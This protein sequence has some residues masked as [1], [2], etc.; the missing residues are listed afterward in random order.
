MHEGYWRSGFGY[1]CKVKCRHGKNNVVLTSLRRVL[2]QRVQFESLRNI[3][4]TFA[5]QQHAA[6]CTVHA[7]PGGEEKPGVKPNTS[8]SPSHREASHTLGVKGEI[9]PPSYASKQECVAVWQQLG[10]RNKQQ[11]VVQQRALETV[12]RR[13]EGKREPQDRLCLCPPNPSTLLFI[14]LHH[15]NSKRLWLFF[16]FFLPSFFSPSRALTIAPRRKWHLRGR[17]RPSL[18]CRGHASKSISPEMRFT[19]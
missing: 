5:A 6:D 14:S 1:S 2:A 10:G 12:Q 19:E 8:G 4:V 3:S 13:C 9:S 18:L 7:N 15:W 16:F 11:Q 17:G